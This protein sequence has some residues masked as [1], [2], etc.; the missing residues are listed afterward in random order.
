MKELDMPA[1]LR[2]ILMKLPY[3][4]REKWR[5]VA[6]DILEETGSRAVFVDFVN[7]IEK[8]VKIVS[9]PLFGSIN[10]VSPASYC[11]RNPLVLSH[12][13]KRNTDG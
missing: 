9:D 5:N 3:K 6:C 4:L 2:T 8:Q 13:K 10:D 1:N 7:F 12:S 11:W